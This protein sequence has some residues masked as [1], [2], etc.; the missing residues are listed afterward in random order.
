MHCGDDVPRFDLTIHNDNLIEDVKEFVNKHIRQNWKKE[1]MKIHVSILI[2]ML[3]AYIQ[4]NWVHYFYAELR[5]CLQLKFLDEMH[6]HKFPSKLST[7]QRFTAY[8]L[9]I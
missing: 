7:N 5:A 6:C 3:N 4:F 2:L 9:F 1:D 8:F